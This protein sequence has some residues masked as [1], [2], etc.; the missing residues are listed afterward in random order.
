MTQSKSPALVATS[1]QLRE[2]VEALLGCPV[3]EEYWQRAER[4]ARRKLE[5]AKEMQPGVEYYDDFYLALLTRDTV[6]EMAFSDY[7]MAL[8]L[9][10]AGAKKEATK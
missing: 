4:Y 7:T 2:A 3:P 8:C 6:R 10:R 1:E 5:R 9:E